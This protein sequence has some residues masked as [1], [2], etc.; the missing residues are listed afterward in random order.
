M[1]L[2]AGLVSAEQA[3]KA[4]AEVRAPERQQRPAKPRGGQGGAPR[5]EPQ[6]EARRERSAEQAPAVTLTKEEAQRLFKI[7]QAGRVEGKTRGNRRWYFVSRAG[8]VPYLEVT[9]EVVRDL[10]QGHIAVAESERGEVW[11]V[12]GECAR[13]LAETDPAWIRTAR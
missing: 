2:K 9:D 12:T 5:G 1:L 8:A 11:L 10:E 13:Q 6:R 4:E 3:K 7:A